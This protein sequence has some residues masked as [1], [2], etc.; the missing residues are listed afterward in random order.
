[1]WDPSKDGKPATDRSLTELK[2]D[3]QRWFS[4][5]SLLHER[6]PTTR[7]PNG[8]RLLEIARRRWL[9]ARNAVNQKDPGD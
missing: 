9:E 8:L 4:W 6:L 2:Q 3:E 1:M 7:T 5:L